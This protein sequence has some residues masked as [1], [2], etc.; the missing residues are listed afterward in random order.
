MFKNIKLD[1]NSILNYFFIL[2]SFCLPL[3]RAGISFTAVMI[4]LLWLAEC[5]YKE[6]LKVL[7]NVKFILFV[8]FL[9][10]YLLLSYFWGDTLDYNFSNFKRH[11]YYLVLFAIITSVKKEIIN[12]MLSSFLFGMLISEIISYGLIFELWTTNHGSSS[13]PSPFM[14]HLSYTLFLAI[15]SAILL[16]N[17][18][19]KNITNKLKFYYGLFFITATINLF[20][21]GGRTGQLSFVIIILTLIF[22]NIKKKFSAFL[23]SIFLLT[24]VFVSAYNF[25]STFNL[26][27]HNSINDLKQVYV[28]RNF[29]AS[30]G[31]RLSTWVAT[32]YILEDNLLFGTS[33][34]DLN[35]DYIKY[36]VNN[37]K[38]RVDDPSVMLRNGYHSEIIDVTASGGLIG[39]FLFLSSFYY[40][41]KLQ[42]NNLQ[43]RNIKI[44]LVSGFLF[45]VISDLFLRQ[46]FGANLFILFSGIVIAQNRIE[47]TENTVETKLTTK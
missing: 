30:W 20:L 13:D 4:I 43:I 42:I 9:T 47:K 18:L 7:L 15:S 44:I 11:W 29:T 12:Y 35:Q 22:A 37:P 25:S 24:I 8:L 32:Y 14:N 28:E 17:F 26:R 34:K 41:A 31:I 45:A 3:S 38:I 46:Q 1:L 19:L 6:K 33:I 5:N 40:L 21:T 10:L 2:Y 36:I 39:L 16:S 27:V 23:F